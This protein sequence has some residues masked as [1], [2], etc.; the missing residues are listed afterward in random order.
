MQLDSLKL[1][2]TLQRQ[3]RPGNSESSHADIATRT[4]TRFCILEPHNHK[5]LGM[6]NCDIQLSDSLSLRA[7]VAK[8]TAKSQLKNP[9]VEEMC[10]SAKLCPSF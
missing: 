4:R 7:F 5:L 3:L 9:F 10:S 1:M 6:K 2:H 8:K